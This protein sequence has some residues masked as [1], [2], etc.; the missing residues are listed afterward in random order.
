MR[1][2]K[3]PL[4][5]VPDDVDWVAV[6]AFAGWLLVVQWHRGGPCPTALSHRAPLRV[7][8]RHF[9]EVD[10]GAPLGI[11]AGYTIQMES[12]HADGLW[13]SV[14]DPASY[15]WLPSDGSGYMQ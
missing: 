6:G 15:G 11:K 13:V 5:T 2:D 10:Q 1:E 7:A 14:Q 4:V 8:R 3:I 12:D 9:S